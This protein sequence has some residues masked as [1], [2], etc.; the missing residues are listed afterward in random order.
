MRK[1]WVALG[2]SGETACSLGSSGYQAK[3]KSLIYSTMSIW[4][5]PEPP[6]RPAF[7]QPLPGHRARCAQGTGLI[8]REQLSWLKEGSAPWQ[9][10]PFEDISQQFREQFLRCLELC[11]DTINGR[12]CINMGATRCF[13]SLKTPKVLTS[14]IPIPTPHSPL[15]NLPA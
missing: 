4:S 11:K 7:I 1:E 13:Y 15:L 3:G 2:I 5:H 10:S 6:H 9:P 14:S 8:A 12:R